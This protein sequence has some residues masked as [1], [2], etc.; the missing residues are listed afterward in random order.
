MALSSTLRRS[1]QWRFMLLACLAPGSEDIAA[2]LKRE[3]ILQ[4]FPNDPV[5]TVMLRA[6][7]RTLQPEMSGQTIDE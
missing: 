6:L 7:S 1:R 3:E 5:A 2:M 4:L